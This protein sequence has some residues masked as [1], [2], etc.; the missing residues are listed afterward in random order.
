MR[1]GLCILPQFRWTEAAPMW[2]DAEDLGFAH[3]WTYDHLAWRSLA[4]EPW[5]AT[6]PTLT[7]AALATTTIQLG[8]FVATPNYRHPV[9]FAKD[10]LT[11]DDISGGRM[12]LGLGAGGGGFD[13][14]VLGQEPLT[15][16]QK[17]RR[18]DEF[19]DLLTTML[20]QPVTD[21]DGE[22]YTAVGARTYPGPLAAPPPMLVA[23]NGPRALDV[24]VRHGQGWVTTGIEQVD[25]VDAWWQ[26]LA[27][28]SG[29]LDDALE[30]AG[31]S[32][33]V[34]DHE[35]FP[36]Y[37]NL[38]TFTY[39]LE[40][41]GKFDDMV[42]RAAELGFTDVVVHRPRTDGIYAGDPAILERLTLD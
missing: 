1:V 26:S 22:F 13:A 14:A 20:T 4:D 11:L 2:R 40:S 41:V 31:R 32:D 37:L 3:V 34:A 39:S 21:H 30:R 18:L 27:T 12:L 42:G 9:T 38:D 15:P 10:V 17:V 5:F 19:C 16:G 36:R 35:L 33:A 28:L 25:D 8:T 29:R 6:V 23:G 24:V 7:A